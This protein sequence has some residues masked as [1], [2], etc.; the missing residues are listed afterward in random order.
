MFSGEKER[1][2]QAS[3]VGGL[4]TECL[5]EAVE[6]TPKIWGRLDNIRF[7]TKFCNGLPPRGIDITRVE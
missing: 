6:L 5:S 7:H 2:M 4:N 1:F 3:W